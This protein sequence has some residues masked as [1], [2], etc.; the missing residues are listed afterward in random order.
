MLYYISSLLIYFIYSS[1]HLLISYPYLAPC[2]PYRLTFE[3]TCRTRYRRQRSPD[4]LQGCFMGR[5]A[6]SQ[7]GSTA[8]FA[9]RAGCFPQNLI[10]ASQSWEWSPG[11]V[12]VCEVPWPWDGMGGTRRE[13]H[14]DSW[15]CSE[16]SGPGWGNRSHHSH[17]E[18]SMHQS[19][20]QDL[21]EKTMDE[22]VRWS[23]LPFLLFTDQ[24]SSDGGQR[25]GPW[26]WMGNFQNNGNP[27]GQNGSGPS[28]DK[29]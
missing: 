22:L 18:L 28:T 2:P 5:Q 26:I 14:E 3:A 24:V 19:H 20:S 25:N 16:P 15:A 6:P 29:L 8:A 17:G 9:E 7:A 12:A 27:T 4:P 1:L 21:W 13:F 11:T 10:G 23:R